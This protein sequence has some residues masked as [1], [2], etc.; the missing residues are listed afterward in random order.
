MHMTVYEQ[1]VMKMVSGVED[2]IVTSGLT[3][4]HF[5]DFDEIYFDQ[6]S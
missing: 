1:P 3:D 5:S 4:G 2:V 6:L